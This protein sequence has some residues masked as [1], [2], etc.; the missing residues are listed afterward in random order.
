MEIEKVLAPWTRG[1]I[2]DAYL[3]AMKLR[4]FNKSWEEVDKFLRTQA[5]MKNRGQDIVYHGL[6]CVREGCDK[7]MIIFEVNSRPNNQIGG[8]Y[9][10]MW[11]CMDSSCN[12]TYASELTVR[13]EMERVQSLLEVERKQERRR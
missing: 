9:K 6:P 11:Y 3:I 7:R 1:R 4:R 5:R 2:Q 13:E 8:N 10:S 12:A